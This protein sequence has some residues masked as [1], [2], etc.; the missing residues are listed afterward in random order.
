VV[1]FS[2][3]IRRRSRDNVVLNGPF[4]CGCTTL[5]VKI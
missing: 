4:C 1:R 2:Q 3:K 5:E